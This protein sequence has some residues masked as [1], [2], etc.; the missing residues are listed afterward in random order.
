MIDVMKKLTDPNTKQSTAF[1]AAL[2]AVVLD[3]YHR[4]F[5]L[6]NVVLMGAL[7]GIT[8]TG[9]MATILQA[10]KPKADNE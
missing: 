3:A 10:A 4:G 6:W 2:V 1:Y 9:L 5:H 8:V 7:C